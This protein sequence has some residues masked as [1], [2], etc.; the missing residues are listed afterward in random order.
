MDSQSVSAWQALQ[1]RQHPWI[2]LLVLMVVT[3]LLTQCSIVRPGP[4]PTPAP[5]IEVALLSGEELVELSID[6]PYEVLDA[7]GQKIAGGARLVRGIA[8]NHGASGL[9]LNGRKL[10]A[11]QVILSPGKGSTVACG[12]RRYP[13]DLL[14]SAAGDRTLSVIN[15]LDF[16]TYLAGVLFAEMPPSFPDEALKA[17]V[18]AARSYARW[19][20]QQGDG[21]LEATQNDQVYRGESD[22][23]ARRL[24]AQTRGQVLEFDDRPLPTYFSSTCGG[25]TGSAARVFHGEDLAPLRGKACSFCRASPRYR[26]TRTLAAQELL[27][28]LGL[29][30]SSV[31]R[32]IELKD[33]DAFERP[34]TIVLSQGR[35]ERR[36]DSQRFRSLWNQSAPPGEDLPSS[37]LLR[38]EVRGDRVHL[39]GAGFG[40]GVGM[41]QYGCQGL[42]ERG[43]DYRKIL[44][45]Y[46][47][48]SRLVRRW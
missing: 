38:A 4:E 19:R 7:S 22:P 21:V 26:W 10:G 30:S 44:A 5:A 1:Q 41:C 36:I 34:G 46:Y 27:A 6:G 25:A 37:F 9:E 8:R 42:A 13:G 28:R 47:P 2:T 11:Q 16:E 31:L 40:H 43:Q 45:Y 14:L 20:Q 12:G 32:A 33:R 48:G 17:Q 29:P 18:I 35:G 3:S 23:R 24:V 39:E 15:R